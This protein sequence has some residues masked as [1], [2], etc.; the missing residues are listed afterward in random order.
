MGV[1]LTW[2]AVREQRADGQQDLGDCEGR[3]PLVLQ[4]VKADLAVA[5]DVA[6]VDTSPECHLQVRDVL[7]LGVAGRAIGHAD[8][9]VLT[10]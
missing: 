8:R 2:V 9:A 10:P 1:T 3:A 7:R 4:D 5:V 6:V